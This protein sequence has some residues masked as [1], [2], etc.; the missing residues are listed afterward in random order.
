MYKGPEV[1]GSLNAEEVSGKWL[2]ANAGAQGMDLGGGGVMKDK[3]G[4][5]F[6]GSGHVEFCRPC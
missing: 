3:T 1:N 4:G 6:R 5:A 2:K